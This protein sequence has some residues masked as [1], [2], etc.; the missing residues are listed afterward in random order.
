MSVSF[1]ATVTYLNS[2]LLFES[3]CSC[4][5]LGWGLNTS[6]N[7]LHFFFNPLVLL[8]REMHFAHAH[9][10]GTRINWHAHTVRRQSSGMTVLPEN[11]E[12]LTAFGY[13]YVRMLSAKKKQTQVHWEHLLSIRHIHVLKT[14]ICIRTMIFFTEIPAI[15]YELW[16]HPVVNDYSSA[17]ILKEVH[18]NIEH[19]E[20]QSED[21]F[22]K[23]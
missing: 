17:I 8:W 1:L 12:D 11:N 14:Y 16:N 3:K 6:Q 20:L 13:D 9:W 23:V 10:S 19:K 15:K 4:H 7:S 5:F 21:T 22:G 18:R 2:R